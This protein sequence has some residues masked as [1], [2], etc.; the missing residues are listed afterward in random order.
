MK[1]EVYPLHFF[2]LAPDKMKIEENYSLLS[3]NSFGIEAKTRWFVS[4]DNEGELLRILS[5]EYFLSLPFFHIGS[6]SNLLFLSDYEGVVL[7]SS[8]SD[9]EVADENEDWV[10]VKV[11][12][13]ADWDAFVAYAVDRGWGGIENL[14]GIP[15]QVGAA[16]IQNIGAYGCEVKDVLVS[17]T[18]WDV[19]TKEKVVLSN[20]DCR[21]A[22]RYSIFK[23]EWKGKYIITSVSFR[24]SKNPEYNLEYGNLQ[25]TLGGR[26]VNLRSVREAV[27]DIRNSK[28]PDPKVCGNA[29]SFFMNP[30]IAKEQYEALKLRYPDMPCYPVSDL[31][32]KVPAAWLIDRCGL[33]GFRMGNAAVHDR[34]ALVL[35]NKGGATGREVAELADLVKS[36]VA[37]K[38]GIVLTPEVTYIK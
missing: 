2:V 37:D 12:A 29:G 36:K 7:H 13:G 19:N 18:A 34:Q 28:L 1:E 35:V 8:I 24:L 21:F 33:K 17:L 38:Y 15:S 5:D 30:Y 23:G 27:I 22:Y 11:G 26:E 25:E 4:Y 20:A 16:A 9:I 31:Q 32:V 3:H 10:E 14:S 6:G